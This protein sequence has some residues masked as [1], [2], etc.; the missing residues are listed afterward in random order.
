MVVGLII[1]RNEDTIAINP[2]G[3][4][5]QPIQV[6]LRDIGTYIFSTCVILAFGLYG[7]L[8]LFAGLSLLSIY[9]L[10]VAFIAFDEFVKKR[11][12]LSYNTKGARR[13]K[14]RS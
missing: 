5:F 11:R 4:V 12:Y 9:C 10:L 7:S 2:K 1:L 6:F 8:N 3:S 13:Q 14:I